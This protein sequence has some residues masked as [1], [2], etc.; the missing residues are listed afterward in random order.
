[1]A[2]K[3]AVRVYSSCSG[4]FWFTLGFV[5]FWDVCGAE[6]RACLV[7][8]GQSS[9]SPLGWFF[10]AQFPLAE[11][12]S[13]C[14]LPSSSSEGSFSS[15]SLYGFLVNMPCCNRT[16]Q[17]KTKLPLFQS[18]NISWNNMLSFEIL[19]KEYL[20]TSLPL[21]MSHLVRAS[22]PFLLFKPLPGNLVKAIR[23]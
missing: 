5:L 11:L 1:M 2:L 19:S 23:I 20:K 10:K 3:T 14:L 6:V 4:L 7:E 12:H 18:V 9:F 8:P 21:S 15:P 17:W 22:F 13:F 16:S